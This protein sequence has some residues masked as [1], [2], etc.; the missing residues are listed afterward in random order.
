MLLTPAEM[1]AAEAAVF[2]RGADAETLME[3][4]GLGMAKAV[5]ARFPYPGRAVAYLGTGHNAGDALVVSRYL[6]SWGWEV[7]LRELAPPNKTSP[8]TQKKRAEFLG[9]FAKPAHYRMGRLPPEGPLILLDGLLGIGARGELRGVYAERCRE[10]NAR[11]EEEGAYVVAMDLPTGL[12]GESGQPVADAVMADL[13]LTVAHAKTG[14]LADEAVSHVGQLE[15]IPVADITAPSEGGDRGAE[16][17]T[18]DWARQRFR[19]RPV[20]HYKNRAGRV[21]V[22]AGSRGLTGAAALASEGALA[23][24]AGLVSLYVDESIYPIMASRCSPEVMVKALP[25]PLSVDALSGIPADILAIGPGLGADPVGELREWMETEARPMVIDAD[26][27]NG[28]ALG[29]GSVLRAAEAGPRLLTPHVGEFK[30]LFPQEVSRPTRRERA[31]AV[32]ARY[33]LTLLYKGVRT[34]VAKSGAPTTYNL[35]GNPG[36]ASGGM[37]DVLT[38]VC[39]GLAAQGYALR[40]AAS[41]GAW[42]CGRAA[43]HAVRENETVESL[44]A[45][46]VLRYLARAQRELA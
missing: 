29:E 9:G 40:E 42:L 43:D 44:R 5:R 22:V 15:L 32:V 6:S 8:L 18:L 11:R 14:L 10:M 38:G 30:R 37:G 46:H 1:Q 28:L 26:G 21:A 3:T 16:V 17:V 25:D 41:L 35:S 13:T 24:G 39:A 12:D 4:A 2:A 33:P 36:M 27:L 31:E 7:T 34:L 45:S 19:R 20:D 23:A